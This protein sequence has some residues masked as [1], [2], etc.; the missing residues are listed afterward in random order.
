[1]RHNTKTL[2]PTKSGNIYGTFKPSPVTG[3]KVVK[4]IGGKKIV[5]IFPMNRK[6]RRRLR[7][8]EVK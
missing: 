4:D 7:I 8:K 6:E 5:N 1:M 3:V 2:T